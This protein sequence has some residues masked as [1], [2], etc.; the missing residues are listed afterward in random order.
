MDQF[1]FSQTS[2][3]FDTVSENNTE[4]KYHARVNVLSMFTNPTIINNIAQDITEENTPLDTQSETI[5][6]LEV[7]NNT[8][9][10]QNNIMA[11]DHLESPY[12]IQ[13]FKAAN[14]QSITEEGYLSLHYMIQ[15]NQEQYNNIIIHPENKSATTK[16]ISTFINTDSKDFQKLI[17]TPTEQ[18]DTSIAPVDMNS[19]SVKKLSPVSETE[20]MSISAD[21]TEENI[22]E[23]YL[24]RIES[25]SFIFTSPYRVAQSQQQDLQNNETQDSNE[26]PAKPSKTKEIIFLTAILATLVSIMAY[27]ITNTM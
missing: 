3:E 18:S 12:D 25:P 24:Q 26:T 22:Q 21:I 9:P 20:S 5:E 2:S 15:R 8:F 11:F 27:I 17:N 16:S 19:E 6:Q 10:S 1:N 4:N 23:E 7:D 14:Q 13:N